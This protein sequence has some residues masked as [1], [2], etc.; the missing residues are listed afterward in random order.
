MFVLCLTHMLYYLRNVQNANVALTL[1]PDSKASLTTKCYQRLYKQSNI[2]FV[3]SLLIAP[4]K[5]EP[6]FVKEANNLYRYTII[7]NSI[8]HYNNTNTNT[9]IK[10]IMDIKSTYYNVCTLKGLKFNG[11]SQLY[12]TDI[13]SLCDR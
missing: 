13:L 3:R 12:N 2:N 1:S 7:K 11:T 5:H 6:V 9:W 10:T 8:C 4:P